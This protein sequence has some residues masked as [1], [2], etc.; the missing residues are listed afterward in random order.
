MAPHSGIT[1]SSTTLWCCCC[2]AISWSLFINWGEPFTFEVV[3]HAWDRNFSFFKSCVYELFESCSFLTKKQNC[4]IL[5]KGAKV[6]SDI[7]S[8]EV[9]SPRPFL[10]LIITLTI[11]EI[12][13]GCLEAWKE[14]CSVVLLLVGTGWGLLSTTFSVSSTDVSSFSWTAVRLSLKKAPERR[15]LI[16]LSISFT[17]VLI[18]VFLQTFKIAP[19]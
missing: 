2:G 4:S 9:F 15:A 11:Q 3:K 1:K 17:L 13:K 14:D 8:S 6:G 16:C 5:D 10:N 18:S 19:F 7:S 12:T